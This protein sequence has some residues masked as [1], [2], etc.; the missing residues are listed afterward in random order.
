MP[1]D[2]KIL[3]VDDDEGFVASLSSGLSDLVSGCDVVTAADGV[4][5]VEIIESRP[6]DLLVTDLNMPGMS[7]FELMTYLGRHHPRIRTIVM[8]AFGPP[9]MEAYLD[10][11]GMSGYVEKPIDIGR[12]AGLVEEA[13]GAPEDARH[14]Q[15]VPT[16]SEAFLST[17]REVARGGRDG[18]IVVRSADNVG[19]VFF[20][21]GS[22][23]WATASTTAETFVSLLAD[24]AGISMNDLRSVYE[25][26][27]QTGGNFAET[28]VEWKLLDEDTARGLLLEHVALGVS[29]LAAW[30]GDVFVV[31]EKRRYAGTIRFDLDQVLRLART[32]Q[33]ERRLRNTTER[34]ALRAHV[35]EP[36]RVAAP[37][38]AAAEKPAVDAAAA[39]SSGSLFA[40]VKEILESLRSID[41]FI[42]VAAF[43]ASGELIAEVSAPGTR[44][45]ELG[46]LANDVL[47][48]S[49][50]AT[51][52]MGVGRG[53]EVQL[54]APRANILARC[55]N[56][57]ADFSKTEPGRAHV[58]L[59]L[60]L[61]PEGNLG[62]GKL[63][64]EKTIRRIAPLMR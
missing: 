15:A 37:G 62:L 39:T 29:H 3:L 22:V 13:L 38:A 52:L 12:L 23:V 58:H 56:E 1:T 14:A 54:S 19:R 25:A 33:N 57:N 44:L 43:T 42:G 10:V 5:A 55:L 30:K 35:P 7:G 20:S 59:M 47:L 48:K 18:E 6:I 64:L 9:D 28:L 16:S 51:E 53:N 31:P 27:R 24:R 34:V 49:Q 63:H 45:G 11:P 4:G 21:K 41:G 2:R 8:S 36:R 40:P 50:K 26:C 60:I 61:T 32:L 46:A 17:A